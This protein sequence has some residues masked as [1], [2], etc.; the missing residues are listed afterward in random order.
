MISKTIF[1]GAA[2]GPTS[3]LPAII[4]KE[5]EEVGLQPEYSSDASTPASRRCSW[6]LAK[7]RHEQ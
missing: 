1:K 7:V 2:N 6:G 5:D 3:L 4:I